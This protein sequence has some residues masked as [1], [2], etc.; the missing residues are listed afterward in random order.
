MRVPGREFGSEKPEAEVIYVALRWNDST[1]TI[2]QEKAM[3][4]NVALKLDAAFKRDAALKLD[5]R[6]ANLR[7]YNLVKQQ[8]NR[9]MSLDIENE[10]DDVEQTIKRIQ[11]LVN[12][13]HMVRCIVV[14]GKSGPMPLIALLLKLLFP[15]IRIEIRNHHK[16]WAVKP[17]GDPIV[18]QK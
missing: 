7:I 17:L 18:I 14:G 8:K 6:P 5:V 2:D 4:E 9:G 15:R 13:S 12:E 3:V 11:S 1:P 16:A 10:L